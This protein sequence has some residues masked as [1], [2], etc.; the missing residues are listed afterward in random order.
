MTDHV[1]ITTCPAAAAAV[2][3]A[4]SWLLLLLLLFPQLCCCQQVLQSLLQCDLWS[5][6]CDAGP[7]TQPECEGLSPVN[8]DVCQQG[9]GWGAS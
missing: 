5:V 1:V 9:L 3:R 4:V 6:K 2:G 8:A 7:V